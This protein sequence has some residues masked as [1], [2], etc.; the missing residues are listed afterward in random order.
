MKKKNQ[1]VEKRA[2]ALAKIMANENISVVFDNSKTAAFNPTSRILRLPNFAKTAP[3]AVLYGFNAHEISH[4]LHTPVIEKVTALINIVED[5]RVER[6]IKR[7]FKGSAEYMKEMYEYL[8]T[9]NF[10]GTDKTKLKTAH[11]L[12]RL[13]VYAKMRDTM[14]LEIPF[15]PEEQKLVDMCFLTSSFEDVQKVCEKIKQFF[16]EK[17]EDVDKRLNED[18]NGGEKTQTKQ[19]GTEE[20]TEETEQQ[21]EETEETEQQE[22][23]TEETEQQEE[24]T[25]ETEQQENIQQENEDLDAWESETEDALKNAFENM[26]EDSP[27]HARQTCLLGSVGEEIVLKDQVSEWIDKSIVGAPLYDYKYKTADEDTA[28][29][30]KD[31]KSHVAYM[32]KQFE[33]KKRASLWSNTQSSNTGEL[34]VS[35][36]SEYKFADDLFLRDEIIPEGKSHGLVLAIDFSGSMDNMIL[37]VCKQAAVL[38]MFAR[39]A[40]IPL[41]VYGFTANG[42]S[43]GGGDVP[44]TSQKEVPTWTSKKHEKIFEMVDTTKDKKAKFDAAIRRLVNVNRWFKFFG[45]GTPLNTACLVLSGIVEKWKIE[46]QLE[47]V[48]TVFLTD[49]SSGPIEV[50]TSKVNAQGEEY[51]SNLSTY[52]ITDIFDTVT[53]KNYSFSCSSESYYDIYKSRTGSRVTVFFIGKPIEMRSLFYK[54]KTLGYNDARKTFLK[55]GVLPVEVF[56]DT[57]DAYILLRDE[58]KIEKASECTIKQGSAAKRSFIKQA[59]AKAASKVFVKFFME[60]MA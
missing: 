22:E 14:D 37:S 35:R 13:N 38:A 26:V 59:R 56:P 12:D 42:H 4:A 29:F 31:T 20:E 48:N 16:A 15:T 5:V 47:V 57:L 11:F 7:K 21:E 19:S 50:T 36:L 51:L 60:V 10:F 55:D 2:A 46:N 45:G 52:R 28:K 9:E 54:S 8:W 27:R 1:D 30:L 33:M 23:E 6:L 40:Q 58:D 3:E 18:E 24:E 49:G 41:K 25:E 17:N 34:D 39:Q 43:F 53:K 32:V 44:S